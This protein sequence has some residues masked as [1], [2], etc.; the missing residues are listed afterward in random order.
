MIFTSQKVLA[1]FTITEIGRLASTFGFAENG[2]FRIRS[3]QL[4]GKREKFT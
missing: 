3:V 1:D 4:S 2:E